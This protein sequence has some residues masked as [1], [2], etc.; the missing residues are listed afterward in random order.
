MRVLTESALARESGGEREPSNEKRDGGILAL[1]FLSA[2]YL[3]LTRLP[4]GS[5]SRTAA[6]AAGDP[7]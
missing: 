6:R 5:V 7:V 1:L 2:L 4:A 3:A